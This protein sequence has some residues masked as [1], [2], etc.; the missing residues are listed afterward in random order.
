MTV[1][2]GVVSA[3]SAASAAKGKMVE[4]RKTADNFIV[5]YDSSSSTGD[6][7]ADTDMKE[8]DAERAILKEKVMTLPEL[9]WNAGIYTFTPGWSLGYF[10]PLLSMRTYDK[11]EFT[12]AIEALPSRPSG[13]T[14]L[15]GGLVGLGKEL[16]TLQGRTVVFLFTDGQYSSQGGFPS[17]GRIAANIAADNDVCFKVVAT[18]EDKAQY[19]AIKNIASVNE[20]SSVIPFEDLLGHPDWLTDVLFEVVEMG[21]VAENSSSEEKVIKGETFEHVLF[22]FDKSD[23]TEQG[24]KA[25]LE[26]SI[27]MQMNPETRV[28]L[29][30]YT[31]SIGTREYNMELSKKRAESARSY[32][33][34]HG[35]I[36]PERV[37]LSW[38]GKD[39][40]ASSNET[41][42]GRMKNRRVTAVILD[43]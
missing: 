5:M 15:Q 16:E 22:E 25:L 37:T 1:L 21:A 40:P 35:L 38:F 42:A 8:I 10:K 24:A 34:E 23:I 11:N 27:F 9:D 20:C 18:S 36:T 19:Q 30:G 17:P 13:F 26:L 4:L 29:A 41:E 43:K 2:L 3:V 33:T 39:D 28:V 31:D 32:L 7:Y 14:P 12:Q 6:R